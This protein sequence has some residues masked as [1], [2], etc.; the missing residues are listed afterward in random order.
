VLPSKMFEAM[1]T[2][3]AVILGVRGESREML[4]R[5]CSGIAIE[6]EDPAALARAIA[7]LADNPERCR[8]LGAAGRK[9][10]EEN[11]D[12]DRLAMAMLDVLRDVAA[13]G[14]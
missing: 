11:H 9:F 2:G 6:P 7:E 4:Q 1:S 14:A 5:A 13:Q 8:R 12:R 3:R 10:V